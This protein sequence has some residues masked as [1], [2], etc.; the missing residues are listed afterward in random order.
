MEK[1]K[2]LESEIS[3]TKEYLTKLGSDY[4]Q[5]M[6]SLKSRY[7]KI[8]KKME[9][10]HEE[11]VKLVQDELSRLTKQL[12]HQETKF[13]VPGQILSRTKYNGEKE[14]ILITESIDRKET[15]LYRSF[16]GFGYVCIGTTGPGIKN[17]KHCFSWDNDFDLE[18]VCDVHDFVKLCEKHNIK[19][20]KLNRESLEIIYERTFKKKLNKRFN[21]SDLHKLGIVTK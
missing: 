11:K 4:H 19:K 14:F 21:Y 15:D 6:T 8:L 1:L 10:E 9:D 5:K 18:I 2:L 12:I 17:H 20:P 16:K 13:Y 7:Y 3:Q